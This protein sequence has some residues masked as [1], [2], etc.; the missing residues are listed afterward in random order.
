MVG[1]AIGDNIVVDIT[2]YVYTLPIII[3]IFETKIYTKLNI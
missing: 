3:I 2:V 1:E